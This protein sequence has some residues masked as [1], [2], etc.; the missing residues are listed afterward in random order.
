MDGANVILWANGLANDMACTPPVVED[1]LFDLFCMVTWG[2][3]DTEKRVDGKLVC[4]CRAAVRRYEVELADSHSKASMPSVMADLK[5]RLR[6]SKQGGRSPTGRPPPP[7]MPDSP[8]L[9]P[10]AFSRQSSAV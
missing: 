7:P 4:C 6:S 1:P 3:V 2:R 8:P 5:H 9:S 10:F